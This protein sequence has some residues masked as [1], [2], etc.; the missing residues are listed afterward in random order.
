[1]QADSHRMVFYR[2]LGKNLSSN[3]VCRLWV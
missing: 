1:M 3:K 2:C